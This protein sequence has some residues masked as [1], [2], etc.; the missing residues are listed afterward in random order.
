MGTLLCPAIS[1]YTYTKQ[2]HNL[3]VSNAGY[4]ICQISLHFETLVATLYPIM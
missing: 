4:I 1:I 3:I 2:C